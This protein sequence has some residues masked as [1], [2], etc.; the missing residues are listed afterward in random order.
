MKKTICIL[1]FAAGLATVLAEGERKP[2]PYRWV[3]VASN[4]RHDS[5]V[6]RIRQIVI[7]ASRARAKR[8]GVFSR[9]RSAGP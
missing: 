4:L 8:H 2:Y 9:A 3:R 1:L 7:T 6:D 5:E